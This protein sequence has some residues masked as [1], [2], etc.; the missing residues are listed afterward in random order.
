[1]KNKG[2]EKTKK[3]VRPKILGRIKGILPK[4]KSAKWIKTWKTQLAKFQTAC[5]SPLGPCSINFTNSAHLVGVP[6]QVVIVSLFPL[7]APKPH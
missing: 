3:G 7:L 5:H 1:M 4:D 2:F 6:N